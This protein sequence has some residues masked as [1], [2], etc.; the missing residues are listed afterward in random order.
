MWKKAGRAIFCQLLSWLPLVNDFPWLWFD[1]SVHRGYPDFA[2]VPHVRF[3]EQ[4]VVW[5]KNAGLRQGDRRIHQPETWLFR[6]NG[7]R[8]IDRQCWLCL[9]SSCKLGSRSLYRTAAHA[10]FSTAESR[11]PKG[12]Q[13]RRQAREA[14]KALLGAMCELYGVPFESFFIALGP[15]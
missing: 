14:L 1:A 13:K 9:L 3:F 8:R 4:N 11:R 7:E 10:L 12:T 2:L 15:G 5:I 6:I